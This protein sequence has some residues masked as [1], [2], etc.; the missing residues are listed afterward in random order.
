MSDFKSVLIDGLIPVGVMC[1]YV[2]ECEFKHQACNG[3][4]CP[5]S[6]GNTHD[7]KFSCGAARLFDICSKR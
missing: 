2:N 7:L 6:R 3:T 5:Y 4:G 1:P